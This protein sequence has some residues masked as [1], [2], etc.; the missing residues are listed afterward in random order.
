MEFVN[1][2]K[3][4]RSCVTCQISTIYRKEREAPTRAPCSTNHI[5]GFKQ[6]QF[7]I[8]MDVQIVTRGLNAIESC[9]VAMVS[10]PLTLMLNKRTCADDN[11]VKHRSRVRRSSTHCFSPF[12]F[13]TD[14]EHSTLFSLASS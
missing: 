4:K 13:S 9:G 8:G 6:Q 3:W 2:Q 11:D 1:L 12:G 7:G 14:A 10:E 5:I